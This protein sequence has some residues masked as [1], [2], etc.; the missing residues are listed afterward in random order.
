MFTKRTPPRS[1][2]QLITKHLIN[3]D[4]PAVN[5]NLNLSPSTTS[6]A[7]NHLSST[8]LVSNQIEAKKRKISLDNQEEITEALEGERSEMEDI[9][10]LIANPNQ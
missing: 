6:E 9:K 1:T 8:A 4:S 3:F 2:Q 7:V 5:S 10:N